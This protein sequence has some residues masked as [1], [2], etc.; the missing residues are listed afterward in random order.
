MAIAGRVDELEQRILELSAQADIA[1]LDSPLDGN[2][3]MALF[4]RGP[5]PWI[6]P[7]KDRLREL[8][9]DGELDPDDRET[10]TAIARQLYAERAARCTRNGP[11]EVIRRAV[12]GV[13]NGR[14][15]YTIANDFTS[16]LRGRLPTVSHSA[17]GDAQPRALLPVIRNDNTIAFRARSTIRPDQWTSCNT[18]PHVCGAGAVERMPA[19]GNEHAKHRPASVPARPPTPRMG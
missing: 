14:K 2:A 3:L 18:A 5:G 7:I 8:V 4:D 19:A 6:R 13:E 9:I 10:A 17:S 1:L 15:R 11:P 16:P 12:T